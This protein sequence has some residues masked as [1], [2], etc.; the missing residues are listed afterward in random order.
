MLLNPKEVT[1]SSL[2]QP[3]SSRNICQMERAV[4]HSGTEDSRGRDRQGGPLASGPRKY[5]WGSVH[6][7]EV[8]WQGSQ[9]TPSLLLLP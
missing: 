2:L 9:G 5:V 8:D 7:G 3:V 1:V 4:N 6:I